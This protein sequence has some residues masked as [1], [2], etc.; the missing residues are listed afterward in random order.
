VSGRIEHLVSSIRYRV[1][2]RAGTVIIPAEVSLRKRPEVDLNHY[3][4]LLD[5]TI[6]LVIGLLLGSI[7]EYIVHRLMHKGKFLDKR[8]A[9]HHRNFEAQGW[10]GEFTDY[11][12]PGLLIAWV[13]FLVSVPAGVG[14]ALGTVGY[15]AFAAYAHQ[16]QHEK[17]DL[18]FWLVAPIH[19]L[20]HRENMWHHNFG[21]GVSIWDR[22]LGTYKAADWQPERRFRDYPLSEFVS[23]RWR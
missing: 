23:I 17:P 16:I 6:A 22:M 20:H 5:F 10:W 2:G 3:D 14:F 19:F 12:L 21:I 9:K 4:T 1:E 7:V 8:H 13:G 11:A 18:A 15:A